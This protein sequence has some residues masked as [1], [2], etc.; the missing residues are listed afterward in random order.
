MTL[1]RFFD[2]FQLVALAGMGGLAVGR[3]LVL[4]AR[5]IHVVV[6]DWQRTPAQMFSDSILV[7]SGFFWLYEI[8]AYSWPLPARLVPACLGTVLFDAAAAKATGALMLVA[9]VA[10]YGLALRAFG[11]S[12]RLGIDR[13][14]CGPLA[15]GGIFAWTR[16]PVYVGLE[17]FAIGTFLIQGRLIFLVLAGI[18]AG[19]I[20]EQ[21]LREERFLARTYGD[22][23][24]DYC[25]RVGRYVAWPPTRRS[26]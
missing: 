23:Y 19:L 16:N 20:H 14:R 15:T 6:V 3:A 8:V 1:D 12:W 13:E 11:D 22:A 7:M 4:Y 24:R 17:L 10:L 5:G 26:P 18:G 9:G 21:I 2:W 25:A